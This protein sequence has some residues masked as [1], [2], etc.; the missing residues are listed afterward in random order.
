MKHMVP[1]LCNHIGMPVAVLEG[2]PWDEEGKGDTQNQWS[3]GYCR[4]TIVHGQD[5]CI[6]RVAAI[7][8]VDEFLKCK[9]N[10]W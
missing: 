3:R 6:V 1:S 8:S 5:V 9:N 7:M 2:W 10:I 4:S